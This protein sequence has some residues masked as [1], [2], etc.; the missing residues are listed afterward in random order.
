MA[1]SIMVFCLMFLLVS[2]SCHVKC[3][4]EKQSSEPSTFTQSLMVGTTMQRT[5]DK[6]ERVQIGEIITTLVCSH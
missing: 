4:Q 3:Q 5:I 6:C 1:I 2:Y